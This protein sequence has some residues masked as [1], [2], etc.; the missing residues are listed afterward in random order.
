MVPFI[1]REWDSADELTQKRLLIE[2]PTLTRRLYRR[3]GFADLEANTL[4]V[5]IAVDLAPTSTVGEL[6]AELSL[7]QSTVST[8]LARL[9]QRGLVVAKDDPG[10]ARRQRQELTK[11]GRRLVAAFVSEVDANLRQSEASER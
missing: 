5:L 6:V 4:Q 10:D 9:Q 1:P 3:A 11:A 2:V 7:A 8:A